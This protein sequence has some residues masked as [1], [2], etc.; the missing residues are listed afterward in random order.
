MEVGKK[1]ED[2]KHGRGGLLKVLFGKKNEKKGV[3]SPHDHAPECAENVSQLGGQH[4]VTE[5]RRG[6]DMAPGEQPVGNGDVEKGVEY[7]KK[8]Q[9]GVRRVSIGPMNTV[10]EGTGHATTPYQMVE[11][12][13]ANPEQQAV[14]FDDGSSYSGEWRNGIINGR[15]VF[16]WSNGDRFEGEWKDGKQHGQGTFASA[17]GSVYYGGWKDGRKDGDGVYKPTRNLQGPSMLYLR[18]YDCGVML[19]EIPLKVED[20]KDIRYHIKSEIRRSIARPLRPG[21]VIYKGHHSYDLMRQLQ[22]GIMY[23]IAQAKPGDAPL[24]KEDFKGFL[25]QNFPV[26]GDLPAFKY[27]EY[28]P[29]VFQRLRH[30]FGVDDADFL[31]SLT[32]GPALREMPSPGSSGCI[33]F[34]SEDD[35][36]LIKS[37]RKEEMG[38]LLNLIRKYETY[39]EKNPASLIVRFYGIH[40]VRPWLGRNARFLVMGNVLPTEKRMHR[41]YDLKGSTYG[42]TVGKGRLSDPSVTLKDL[43]VD[44]TVCKMQWCIVVGNLDVDYN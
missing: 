18:K 9:N 19:Q 34:L 28:A 30:L 40:R 27:K 20:R 43:D 32:G 37:V 36:F 17:D 3:A 11:H 6:A 15:G 35:R 25:V 16:L 31:V 29:R 14:L 42:R 4:K 13:H 21:E 22:L 2:S 23:S 24:K 7:V 12:L 44:M 26:G 38:M 1:V 33:F 41:R 8:K 10:V 39:I 5:P